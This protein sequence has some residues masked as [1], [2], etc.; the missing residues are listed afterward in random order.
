MARAT[1]DRDRA[2]TRVVDAQ[3]QA[4][5]TLGIALVF[6]VAGPVMLVVPHDTGNWLPLHLVLA[7]GLLSA[8]SGSSQ[9]LAVTWS[10]AP[11]PDDRLAG[12]Q[13][14]LLAAG[15]VIVAVGREL[16]ADGLVVV[17]GIAV[18]AAMVLLAFSLVQVR[19]RGT[20]DRFRPAID[21]YL[22][23]TAWAG[24]GVGLGVV[25]AV[26][27][28]S[29]WWLQLRDAHPAVNLQGLVGLVVLGT[30]PFFVATQAR[31]KMSPAARP[32]RL[33]RILVGLN[34]AVATTAAGH[35]FGWP[36]LA[37]LGYAG[38]ALGILATA[39]VLPAIGMRQLRWAGPR[40]VQLGT[41]ITWWFVTTTLLAAAELVHTLD[42]PAVLAAL[43]IGGFVQILVAS[44]AYL[45]P[46]LRGGGH[47]RLSAGFAITASVPSLV[48]GNVAAG[49][50]LVRAETLA[51]AALALWA[52]DVSYRAVRL[53]VS[54]QPPGS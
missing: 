9:L 42:R 16:D 28:P 8:I 3:R 38:Y 14:W 27:E 23:A 40:L 19:R 21:A 15:A 2:A 29:L 48:F 20:V 4:A 13:R 41:G 47:A 12:A 6:V 46:V 45:G 22:A 1:P 17:G 33:R 7:G 53:V 54:R 44:L 25:V 10:A 5:R 32:P 26:A 51:G 49:A 50:V 34:V 39:R 43:A 24:L 52:I 30:L 11:A 18:A 37:A 35:G 31:T 36:G